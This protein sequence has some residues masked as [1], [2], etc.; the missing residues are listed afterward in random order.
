MDDEGVG[1][2]RVNFAANGSIFATDTS[3]P[4]T[5]AYAIP[6]DAAE[7]GMST[8]E[9][10]FEVFDSADNSSVSAVI[11]IEV[12][13]DQPPSV[14]IISPVAGAEIIEGSL[15]TVVAEANDDVGVSLAELIVDGE[16]I[17]QDNAAPFEFDYRLPSGSDQSVVSLE[18]RVT[19]TVGRA[20]TGVAAIVRRDDLVSPT[21]EFVV[22]NDGSIITLGDSDVAIIIDT[23]GS[24]GS[25]SGADVDGD[26][27][28]DSILASEVIAAQQLLDFL[29]PVTTQ[30]TVIDFSSAAFVEQELTND[31]SLA[32]IALQRILDRGASGGTNF[33]NAM[34]AATDE[35]V[36]PRSRRDATAV[37]LLFS[38]GSASSPFDEI[39]RA[40]RGGVV[41]N[42][43][44]VGTGASLSGL[45]TIADDTGG[46][47]TPVLDA[48]LLYTSPSPRDQRGSRMPSSA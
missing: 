2:E 18:V 16:A 28:L 15:I 19:D 38:D 26:G 10:D 22:P 30:V 14:T 17:A 47:L 33:T 27:E 32:D 11:P 5:W 3:A 41:V 37:Q 25:S 34:R 21:A 4:W 24:A 31:F 42:T 39:E 35:L 43:F 48:C 46:V 45:Q 1:V 20:T 23:S 40:S 36:G 9:L 13:R 6:L 44:A 29:D 12:V 7:S 8:I